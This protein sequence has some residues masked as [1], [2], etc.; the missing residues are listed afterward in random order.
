M[1]KE[2]GAKRWEGSFRLAHCLEE[3]E[4]SWP[5]AG[6]SPARPGTSGAE[7]FWNIQLRRPGLRGV[8]SVLWRVSL[9][10]TWGGGKGGPSY[11]Q[12][13]LE[14]R[15]RWGISRWGGGQHHHLRPPGTS[16]M[17]P[18]PTPGGFQTELG[19]PLGHPRGCP[20]WVDEVHPQL[21]GQTALS[22]TIRTCISFPLQE[23]FC[24]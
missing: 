2:R 19:G 23:G 18:L 12:G 6:V 16:E 13:S 15:G 11:C 17:P 7:W 24:H 21:F 10:I 9:G 22:L 3:A 8:G 1:L 4:R 5:G 14:A 20:F